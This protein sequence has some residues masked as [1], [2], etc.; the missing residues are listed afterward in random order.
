[1]NLL[2]FDIEHW[3]EGYK[4]RNVDGWE[5]IS[6]RDHY[7]IESVLELLGNFDQRATF[8]VTGVFAKEFPGLIK[9]ISNEG[10]E[11]ASHFLEHTHLNQYDDEIVFKKPLKESVDILENIIGKQLF[12]FRAPFWSLSDSNMEMVLSSIQQCGLIYDSSLFPPYM[13]K[14]PDQSIKK[15]FRYQTRLGESVWE[16]PATY[17]QFQHYR[18]PACGG[19]YLRF[20]PQWFTFYVLSKYSEWQIPGMVY[21][22]PYDMDPDCPRL[23]GPFLFKKMRYYKLDKTKV[24]LETLLSKFR[25]TSIMNWI[26]FYAGSI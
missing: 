7:T 5:T 22:H 8:F 18:I 25:F 21:L 16:F 23:P 15:P 12:G 14:L 20:F 2:T 19:F 24:V 11:I 1:V 26:Q 3:Y 6:P 9:K 17:F 10:H 4:Q 13:K